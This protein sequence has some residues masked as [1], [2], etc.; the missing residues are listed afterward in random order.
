[1]QKILT[2]FQ[3]KWKA[4]YTAVL[5]RALRLWEAALDGCCFLKFG[6]YLLKGTRRA[7]PQWSGLCQILH[8][9]AKSPKQG[10]KNRLA[11]AICSEVLIARRPS[12]YI[13][14]CLCGQKESL[15]GKPYAFNF[16]CAKKEKKGTIWRS[17]FWFLNSPTF[18]L[19]PIKLFDSYKWYFGRFIFQASVEM[20]GSSS[21]QEYM[22][23]AD[24]VQQHECFIHAEMITTLKASYWRK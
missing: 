23:E 10:Q 6:D 19:H 14:K 5:Q 24:C 4:S 15:H 11:I 18:E 13:S 3:A 21:W 17:V 12:F 1:M 2:Y 16:S 7:R 20:I 22:Q 8:T 9:P